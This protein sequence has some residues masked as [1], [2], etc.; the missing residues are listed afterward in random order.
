MKRILCFVVAFA[1]CLTFAQSGERILSF[2][3]AIQVMPSGEMTV[4]ETLKVIS[5]GKEIKRGIYRDFPTIYQDRFGN[6]VKVGFRI[7]S[8]LRD[9]KQ[10]DWHLEKRE[11]G[12]RVYFGKRDRFL[13]LGEHTYSFTYDTDFQVGFFE[14]HDELYWNVTGN[15]WIFPIDE[16][17]ATV[18]LPPG[19]T[20]SSLQAYTGV[21][22]SKE[23]AFESGLDER[24]LAVF[25]TTRKL[26]PTEG[27]TVVVMWPKGFVHEPTREERVKRTL[28]NNPSIGVGLAGI[29]ILFGYY[30][31]VWLIRGK[32]PAKGVIFPLFEAPLG[33]SP[34][35]VRY[36]M[37]MG[38]DDKILSSAVI[39]LA[40]KGYITIDLVDKDEY[41]LT[42]L[43]NDFKE[44]PDDEKHF[45]K[46][47]LG[48]SQSILLNNKK[49]ATISLA[50]DGL[51]EDLALRYEQ[52]YFFT[53][54][55]TLIPGYLI[56]GATVVG[57]AL[58]AGEAAMGSALFLSIGLTIWSVACVSLMSA[59]ASAWSQVFRGGSGWVT[60]LGKAIF[61]TGFS[62]PFLLGEC[63][64]IWMLSKFLSLPAAAC[65]VLV[66][67]VNFFYYHI[68]K[69]PTLQGRQ[70]MDKIE[71]FKQYLSVAEKDRLNEL[72]PPEKTPEI[73][74]KFL[75]Y[76]FALDVE[77]DWC[78]Q[79]SDVLEHA[80]ETGAYV[81][82]WYTGTDFHSRSMQN[83]TSGLNN[84]SSQISSASHP[85]GSNS[86]GGGF[87]GGG[88]GGSSG[89]GGGGG[90]GG[91]W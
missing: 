7:R 28:R 82:V 31:F 30:F 33:L 66:F 24:G 17:S 77:Q 25:K 65:V 36:L 59:V 26:N 45:A 89:G 49:Y 34:P 73:F 86:G 58:F 87:S 40:V 50:K 13:N 11:N 74:E 21:L 5:Q 2:N 48:S 9:G 60:S 80:R 57:L 18:E 19:A 12:T 15:G 1:A 23:A 52:T 8:V 88:G 32:D 85:P 3:S 81:P 29:L 16:A 20:G 84:M 61:Q 53:N 14:D 64:G 10:E 63:F 69:A 38:F 27:L 35:A 76:A 43:R 79:F 46:N 54:R 68:M 42:K 91:G 44:L 55:M 51:K 71:G 70:V 62:I 6:T 39:D 90:G 72:N 47:L 75:P 41:K 67:L 78:E 83:W 4:I 56:S 37:R 22:G